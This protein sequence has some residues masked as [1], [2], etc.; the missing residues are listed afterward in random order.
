ML[1]GEF[2]LNAIFPW[3]FTRALL[4]KL[5]TSRGPVELVF[6]GSC[7]ASFPMPGIVP[8]STGK[9]FIRQLD[10]QF[11]QPSN[12]TT[13]YLNIGGVASDQRGRKPSLFEPAPEDFAKSAVAKIGSGRSVEVPWIWH[14]LLVWVIEFVPE[15]LFRKMLLGIAET[16]MAT[17]AK[18]A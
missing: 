4:P 16:E 15:S 5:R 2:N 12:V 14:A 11:R 9:A 10:E 1:L 6:I 13:L 17:K 8:S 7:T 3:L 18:V